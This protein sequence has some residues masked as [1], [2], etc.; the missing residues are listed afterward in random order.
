[1]NDLAFLGSA[2]PPSWREGHIVDVTSKVGSG[3]TPRGGSAVYVDAGT[4]FIRSQN[5]HDHEF[6]A[7]GLVHIR[8]DAADQL[9]GVTVEPYDV[10][11]NIT[12]DSILR[13]CVVPLHVLPARVSQH[14]AIVRSNG[15]VDPVFMQ[16]WF[17]LP[18]MK[19]FMLGH[20]SGG[21]RK[22][23]T[24]GHILSFPIPIPPLA[25]QRGIAATLGALDDKI[26][27]NRRAIFIAS[28]LLDAIADRVS[29]KLVSV[30]LSEMATVTRSTVDPARL[31]GEQV[32]HFSLP[33]FDDGVW[34]ERVPASSIMSSKLV[35]DGSSILISRL[36]PR[37][38]RTWWVVPEKGITA[39][40]ST[41][42]SCLSAETRSDLAA[43]WLAVRD[44]LFREEITHRVTGTSGSH[45]RIR[46]DD[47]LSIEVPDT[48]KLSDDVKQQ[49]LD[50]LGLINNRRREVRRLAAIRDALLPELLSGRIR[51]PEASGVAS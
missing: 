13:T 23:I 28:D 24:K 39:L 12:G 42:F 8:D 37:F 22:A 46:P 29:L 47:L 9:R 5:V 33:A 51:V 3:A 41:E 31:G 50:L 44:R 32:D 16:K 49:A 18:S 15:R 17:S 10:L 7:D 20:S 38:N 43:L 27:S 14:V 30:P 45:Q 48:R 1:V 35:L 40:A 26:E 11:L 25:E 36:N 21:T 2:L 6:H 4:T 34:P 19:D